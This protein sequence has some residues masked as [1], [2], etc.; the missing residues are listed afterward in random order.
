MSKARW[1]VGI[2]ALAALAGCATFGGNVKGNFR[3]EA[4]GGICAPTTKIDD[5]ALALISG[6]A[7]QG[8]DVPTSAA[9]TKGLSASTQH[10]PRAL[11]IVLPARQDRFGRWREP[12]IVYA[13][14][15][16]EGPVM[17]TGGDRPSA[18][19]TRLSLADLAAGAPELPTLAP[20]G[21][22]PPPAQATKPASREEIADAVKQRLQ[23]GKAALPATAPRPV[24]K[25]SAEKPVA[26]ASPSVSAPSFPASD[27]AGR[28]K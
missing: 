19:Q 17:L 12:T 18:T 20:V 8:G 23:P 4:P 14:L 16:D 10:S 2:G 28:E 22:A 27:A 13:E 26:G 9:V 25:P 21:A 6:D 11:K 7:G 3:C 15:D 1:T 5:Q 24:D